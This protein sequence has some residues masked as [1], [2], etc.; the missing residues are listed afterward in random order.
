[1]S[2]RELGKKNWMKVKREKEKGKFLTDS[3]DS[4]IRYNQGKKRC[5]KKKV[6]ETS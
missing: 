4:F 3:F 1:V 6:R 2:K 5:D